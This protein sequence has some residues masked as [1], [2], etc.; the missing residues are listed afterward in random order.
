MSVS[1]YSDESDNEGIQDIEE[2][3][4]ALANVIETLIPELD[5]LEAELKALERPIEQIALQQLGDIPYLST[6]PFRKATFR[7]RAPGLPGVDSTRRYSFEDICGLLRNYI[8]QANLIAED[9]TITLNDQLK[10]LF[11][12]KE[13]TSTYIELIRHLRNVLV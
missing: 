3:L 13:L 4:T 7:F 10:L 5:T 12:I 6:S 9:E 11:G 2:Q 1:S 8:F